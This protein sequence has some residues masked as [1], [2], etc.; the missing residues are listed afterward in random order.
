[1]GRETH[2]GEASDATCS[3]GMFLGP[4]AELEGRLV[5]RLPTII[6]TQTGTESFPDL[7]KSADF[8]QST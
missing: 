4:S 2:T 3:G 1:M 6:M 8:Y 7:Q 5:D